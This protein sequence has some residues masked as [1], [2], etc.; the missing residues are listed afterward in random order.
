MAVRGRGRG[1]VGGR[2]L[3]PTGGVVAERAAVARAA[4]R[5][6]EGRAVV[7]RE[8]GTATVGS[9]EAR[10]GRGDGGGGDGKEVMAHLEGETLADDDD[11][12][13]VVLLIHRL[14]DQL[15]GVLRRARGVRSAPCSE[16]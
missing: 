4:G 6:A 2:V 12:G 15:R 5:V 9:E 10:T 7:G 11:P 13:L 1:R 14:L 8:V 3:D 16:G